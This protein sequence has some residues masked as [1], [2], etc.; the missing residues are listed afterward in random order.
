MHWLI[1]A[2]GS[3]IALGFYDIC[4]KIS[5]D[6]NAIWP[7]LF[8]CSSIGAL[9]LLPALLTGHVA[10]LSAHG[11]L[12]LLGKAGIV[13]ASWACT[14]TSM[15]HLPI[16][17]SAPVRASSPLF[18]LLIAVL[19]FGERPGPLQGLGIA[20]IFAGYFVFSVAGKQEGIRMHRDPWIGL[21][22]LGTLFAALS[23]AYDKYLLQNC[24]LD[25][26]AVQAWFS[27]YMALQQALL[28]ALIWW[29]RRNQG[30]RFQWRWS[31]LGVG[32]LLLLADR[33]YFVAVH[34]PDALISVISLVRRSNVVISFIGGMY[35]LREKRSPAKILALV[36]ILAGL[37]L[38]L[39]SS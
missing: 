31:I 15:K 18:T 28:A 25:P 30:T 29:P 1:L 27:I 26:L 38:L 33:L 22:L 24:N 7:V 13:T 10:P 4:K 17:I 2:L 20:I 19:C 12:Q 23:G 35:F 34:Q 9:A 39:T 37:S 21:M 36:I 8:L 16:S 6:G 14:Y 32:L 11:H 5:L 3:A